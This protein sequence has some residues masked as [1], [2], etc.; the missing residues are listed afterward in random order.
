MNTVGDTHKTDECLFAKLAAKNRDRV[1]KKPGRYVPDRR[2]SIATVSTT[3]AVTTRD[4]QCPVVTPVG[5]ESTNAVAVIAKADGRRTPSTVL[6]PQRP[7]TTGTTSSKHQLQH[8]GAEETKYDQ[9]FQSPL[10]QF[11]SSVLGISSCSTRFPSTSVRI[12]GILER[13]NIEHQLTIDSATE[14]PCIAKTWMDYIIIKSF[15]A[16]LD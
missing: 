11:Q 16:K 13:D 14:I 7:L 15:R 6:T 10:R 3:A 4:P 2:R 9:F 8:V 5:T 12:F 1:L